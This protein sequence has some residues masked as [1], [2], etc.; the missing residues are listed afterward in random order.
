VR[1]E[2]PPIDEGAAVKI[3]LHGTEDECREIVELLGQVMTVQAVSDPYPDRGRSA[4]V[5]V[6][7]EGIPR[8]G[9]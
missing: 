2:L 6:Y 1:T 3:R 7:V 9:W 4:L 5:Q 8:G